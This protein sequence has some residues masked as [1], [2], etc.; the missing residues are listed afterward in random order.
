MSVVTQTHHD[1]PD[2]FKEV[3]KMRAWLYYRLSRDEDEE[4]NSLQNQR[5]ILVDYAEQN[6]YEIVGESF[7]DN[8][9]GMTFNRKGL[10]K[11]EIAV[12]EGKID[13]VLVKDLSRLG[14]HRTQT[15]LFIDHLRQNNVK[16]ISVTEGIDSFNENDDLLIGF[17]QIFNDFYAKDISKKVKAGVRQKQKSKGLIESLPL[18]YK[19][20]RN[21][22]TVLVDD[23]TAWIVQEVFKL[24]V[25][26]YG[27]T[28][29]ARTMNE[30]GIKS[31]E[32]Y[33]RRKLAD[34]KPDISKKY[35]WVQTSVRRILTN[36]LYIGTMVNHKTVTSKIYKTKTF[37]P[38]EEQY[39]HENFCEPIIDE[40]T[41]KQAQFLLKERSQINPRSQ[42]GRKFHRYS[43][44]IKCADCGASFVARI[45]KWDGK[46]YVEY[47]CNSSHRYG[48][49]YCTPHTVRES[50]LD[51]LIEDEVRGFR[52]TILEESTRYD[53]I[54][55]DWA[56]KKPLYGRQIQQH[57]DKISS[58]RQQIEDLIMEKIGDKEHA[59][60]YNNMIAK[61]E[62]EIKQLDKKISDLREYDKICKQKKDQLKNTTNILDD[63]LSEG[64]IS[65]MNLRMLV[66][67]ILIHQNN[68]KSL[69]I[70]FEMNGEFNPS[71]SVFVEPED[72]TA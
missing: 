56:R 6:G 70:R 50:Q 8:V 38:P 20:D 34:W 45:R 64:L 7:D 71:C 10:G 60:I 53:K 18:G 13:V 66:K 37:I 39:R 42:N 72:E 48:K 31:P 30:R 22:N 65:D 23:E 61:R 12:D 16:V 29:I 15:E 40:T 9:S 1:V 24:Y 46:E 44:L 59:Q 33:Q 21:T 4:M 26:G 17:K 55:K 11:L 52:D 36:E 68:D 63:I 47:T 54:V 49:E 62:E 57:N 25:D 43:R 19:R 14:R 67:K 35:L 5:Q 2:E 28:T 69:D 58:L 27:L 51:E 3:D 41:W 32:Y